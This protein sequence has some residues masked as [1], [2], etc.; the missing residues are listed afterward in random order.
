[1]NAVTRGQRKEK[2]KCVTP[3]GRGAATWQPC[4]PLQSK[5]QLWSSCG[6][7]VAQVCSAGAVL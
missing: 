4:Q 7:C 3:L 2:V 6:C 1:M 5:W